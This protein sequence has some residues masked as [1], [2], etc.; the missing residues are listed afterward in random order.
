MLDLARWFFMAES[1]RRCVH[2][3]QSY[4]SDQWVK[5]MAVTLG[6]ESTLRPRDHPKNGVIKKQMRLS[7][8]F[9]RILRQIVMERWV[10]ECA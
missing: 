7:P 8:F 1:W 10:Q 2:R 4:G 5:R 9:V 6:L 3:S